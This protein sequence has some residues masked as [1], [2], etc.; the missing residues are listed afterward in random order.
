MKINISRYWLCQLAGW[1]TLVVLTYF[2]AL[3]FGKAD[4]SF[5]ISLSC[6]SIIGVMVT[7]VMRYHIRYLQLLKK[8][9]VFQ[10][11]GFLLIALLYSIL[12]GCIIELVDYYVLHYKP[13]SLQ[14]LSLGER[15]FLSSF[16]C[17]WILMIWI[18]V[19]YTYHYVQRNQSQ[20]LDTFRLETL[21]KSLQ[22]KTIKSHINPHFIFNALNSIRALVDENPARA[23]QA[24]TELSNILRSSLATD[25]QETVLLKDELEIVEDYLALEQMR[26]EERLQIELDIDFDTNYQHVPPMMLQTM[27]ENAIK[28]GISKQLAGGFI[29][30]KT[31]FTN[32]FFE[33]I[34]ENSGQFN[35][36]K[37]NDNHGFGL[38]STKERLALIYGD[39]ASFEIK[40]ISDTI[41]S[42]KITMPINVTLQYNLEKI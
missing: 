16:N 7:H 18:F 9:I 32:D 10:I 24:I 14:K 21:V 20:Q 4:R 41:V 38:K 30:I 17:L 33:M 11:I 19:Y 6:T 8:R 15:M 27:V 36:E 1:S 26:F 5:F 25:Q 31:A 35:E 13:G 2:I 29:L 28:H 34:V 3:T 22:L 23:R 40:N 39:K 12:L 37:A 42:C